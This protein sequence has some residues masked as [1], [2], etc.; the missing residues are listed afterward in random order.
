MGHQNK[1]G[2]LW[3]DTNGLKRPLQEKSKVINAF[4][5][6]QFPSELPTGK[7]NQKTEGKTVH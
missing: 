2:N 7:A 5:F 3:R 6:L 4:L 1:A